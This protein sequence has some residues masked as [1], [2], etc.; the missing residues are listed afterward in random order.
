MERVRT[1]YQKWLEWA[2]ANCAAWCR[3][4]E[5]E[6]G[7]RE[8]DRARGIY[9]L[10]IAQPLLDMPEALWKASHAPCL[11]LTGMTQAFAGNLTHGSEC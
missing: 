8:V 11:Q 2:P 7:L 6:A 9:E 1:L 5:L 4:A 10:A 3:F